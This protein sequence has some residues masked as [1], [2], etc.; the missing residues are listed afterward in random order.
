M[1]LAHGE[2]CHLR[3]ALAAHLDESRL[4]AKA[5][6]AALV[7]HGLRHVAVELVVDGLEVLLART[8]LLAPPPLVLV[9]PPLQ[10]REHAL[11]FFLEGLLAAV[12]LEAELDLLPRDA[13][14]DEVA[15]LLRQLAPRHVLV[16]LEVGGDRVEDLVE[17]GAVAPLP[18][19]D[20]SLLQRQLVVGD[21]EIAVEEHL[22]ADAVARGARARRVV[23][24]EQPRRDLRIG[25]P[26]GR[27]GEF[28]REQLVVALERRD[29]DDAARELGR[30]L[31]RVGEALA[32][33]VLLDEPIDEHLDRVLLRLLELGWL[34]QLV[35]LAVDVGAHEA[36]LAQLRELGREL[37]LA[38]AHDGRE[39]REALA[40]GQ[41]ED[42]IHH[43][44]DRLGRD[45][46]PALVAVHLADARPE[47]PQ[48][49]VDLGDCPY[50]R[51]R[52]ARAGLLLDRDGGRQPLDRVEVG[53]VH[54]IQKLP[55]VG[56]E[57]FD[58]TTLPFGV[59]RVEGQRR[60]SGTRQTRDHHQLVARDLDVD[61]LEVVLARA[62]DD[63]LVH[64]GSGRLPRRQPLGAPAPAE[65]IFH[66]RHSTTGGCKFETARLPANCGGLRRF[67]AGRWQ[68]FGRQVA[69]VIGGDRSERRRATTDDAAVGFGSFFGSCDC[70]IESR[71]REL[72]AAFR[73]G[74]L[75]RSGRLHPGD[76][77][78]ERHGRV[79]RRGWLDRDRRP[80]RNRGLE[81]DR[82]VGRRRW[83]DRECRSGGRR[84]R[85]GR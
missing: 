80:G 31:D 56:R 53:L 66:R 63:D 76:R 18:R 19:L 83:R 33:A 67:V 2:G 78:L 68:A 61:V 12:L 30:Q 50:G 77:G 60:L 29:L 75:S 37:A 45:G 28:L 7:A 47:E 15:V 14:E 26:A 25:N 4:L 71:V 9:E 73:R 41:R 16:D 84:A 39:D 20:R 8:P 36:V 64:A 5:R 85:R 81:R 32:D 40:F 22:G 58:V 17:E 72:F 74:G 49:V 1:R 43:L 69:G 27:A 70:P 35:E 51:A 24:G 10:V 57:R 23:E 62:L 82:W 6:A 65:R 13:V 3:D 55:R 48:V 59:D 38:I 34:G 46:Q 79:E 54:L 52:V 11:E 42:L 21:D 44:L